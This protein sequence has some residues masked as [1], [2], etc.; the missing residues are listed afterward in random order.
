MKKELDFTDR[1]LD[2]IIEMS[3]EDR[4]PFDAILDQFKIKEQEVIRIM[5]IELKPTSFRLWRARVQGRKTKHRKSR[6][7]E[8]DRFRCSRQ[9]GISNNKVSK[10]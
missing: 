7:T 6:D 3:W 8:V 1:D 5:R 4:T 2:R 10:R 9:R